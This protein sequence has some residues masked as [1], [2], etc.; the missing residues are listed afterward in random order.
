MAGSI[1]HKPVVLRHA[2]SDVGRLSLHPD[3]KSTYGWMLKNSQHILT[4]S[5]MGN[6]LCGLGAP[7][8]HLRIIDSARLPGLFGAPQKKLNVD[9]YASNFSKWASL[10]TVP[11]EIIKS[12][13]EANSKEFDYTKPTIC[14]Y[15]KIGV[16][17]GSFAI[18]QALDEI[19]KRK[20][21]FNFI[22]VACGH[23][24]TLEKYYSMFLKTK[25]LS[26][27]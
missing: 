18:L 26:K 6:I 15:G 7:R 10:T 12:I 23:V 24:P 22:S 5:G 2:G 27:C 9:D 8:N 4:S 16:T 21:D 17:K 14:C 3:L 25:R 13:Q 19:A 20:I 11:D 1:L